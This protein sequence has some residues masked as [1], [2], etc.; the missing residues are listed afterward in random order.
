MSATDYRVDLREVGFLLFD[1]LKTD[2]RLAGLGGFG[3]Y[4][5]GDYEQILGQMARLAETQIAPSN[6]PGDLEGCTYDPAVGVPHVPAPVKSAFYALREGGWIGA[7]GSPEFGGMGLPETINT[8]LFEM[9]CGANCAL[10]LYPMLIQGAGAMLEKHYEGPGKRTALEHLYAGTWGGTMVLTEPHAGSALG[11]VKTTAKPI[12]GTDEFLIEGTK[13]FITSGDHDMVNNVIHLVL[14]RLP[15]APEGTAGI[16]L[17]MVPKHRFDEN[18]N[19]TG[20]ND[21][22]C[23]RIEH[24]QGINASATCQMSFGGDH[25]DCRGRL[26]GKAHGG[27]KL[28]F[29]MMNEARIEVGVQ[30]ESQAYAAYRN[31]LDYARD[32]KQ[33]VTPGRK[34]LGKDWVT[35]DQHGDVRR[36]LLQMRAYVAGMRSLLYGASLAGDL[37]H[38]HPDAAVR[39]RYDDYLGLITPVC[40][41]Y[42]SDRGFELCGL[43]MQVFGGVGFTKEYPAE[44]YTRDVKIAA[45][46]EGTN[47]IQSLDLVTRKL[48]KDNGRA[49]NAYLGEIGGLVGD[50]VGH[51]RLGAYAKALGAAREALQNLTAAFG[52]AFFARDYT[53]PTTWAPAYLKVFG[54]VALGYELLK[55]AVVADAALQA[56]AAAAGVNGADTAAVR[57][58]AATN[59][60]AKFY[61]QRIDN[62]AFIAG[63]VLPVTIAEAAAAAGLD[64]TPAD[65]LL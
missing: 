26:V 65:T 44:Q 56:R 16:S 29:L 58:F 19:L 61:Q 22:K 6:R 21:V 14:A 41:A 33:G 23:V 31:A 40:K 34:D 30:G 51:A 13:I 45:I 59:E 37:A 10:S 48:A 55:Q 53:G 46:Y 12:P 54:D 27:M 4:T 20:Y 17:F 36:M 3:E 24:K 62:L 49:F 1:V 57:A 28:M 2:E 25:G 5:R 32:R 50:T 39:E 64:R 63:T 52:A 18:G 60:D 15:D 8:A 11:G 9:I 43:S 7:K 35:I 47:G 38:H 42:C